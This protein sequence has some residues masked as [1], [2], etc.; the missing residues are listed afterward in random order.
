LGT[1]GVERKLF[2]LLVVTP[3]SLKNG[4]RARRMFLEELEKIFHFGDQ[5][6][7]LWLSDL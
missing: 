4:S 5:Q 6:A 3:E 1:K 7:G 2:L